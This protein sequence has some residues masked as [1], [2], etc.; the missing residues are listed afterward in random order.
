MWW[1]AAAALAA[2]ED[3]GHALSVTGEV[4]AL[5]ALPFILGGATGLTLSAV[6]SPSEY[7]Q[8]PFVE[9]SYVGVALAGVGVPMTVIGAELEASARRKAGQTPASHGDVAAWAVYGAAVATV[10]V[11][12]PVASAMVDD[13]PIAAPIVVGSVGLASTTLWLCGVGLGAGYRGSLR[14]PPP[15]SVTLVPTGHGMALAGRF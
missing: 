2:P 13:N 5:S 10:A 12:L 7:A 14:D 4:V 8:S 1:F 6:R 15:V 9:L 11:G 3:G